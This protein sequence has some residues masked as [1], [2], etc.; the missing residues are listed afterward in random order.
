[1]YLSDLDGKIINFDKFTY[2][3]NVFNKVIKSFYDSYWK[4]YLAIDF[5]FLYKIKKNNG[6]KKKKDKLNKVKPP[7]IN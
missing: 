3:T 2:I 7:Q 6:Q 4:N 1:M 5:F